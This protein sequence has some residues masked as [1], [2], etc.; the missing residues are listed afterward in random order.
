MIWL[1]VKSRHSLKTDRFSSEY[2]VLV[3]SLFKHVVSALVS[4]SDEFLSDL[5][6][7]MDQSYAEY[8]EIMKELKKEVFGTGMA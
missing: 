8:A 5:V 6:V 2:I 7:V 3:S 1:Q 4:T